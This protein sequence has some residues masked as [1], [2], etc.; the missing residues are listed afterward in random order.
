V[1]AFQSLGQ[2]PGPGAGSPDVKNPFN[3]GPGL[4]Q[5]QLSCATRHE[6]AARDQFC[7]HAG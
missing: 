1:A 4:Y 6:F 2:M 5:L 3:P 7:V